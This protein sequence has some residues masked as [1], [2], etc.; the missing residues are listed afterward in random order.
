MALQRVQKNIPSQLDDKQLDNVIMER[1]WILLVLI[2]SM[3]PLML[4]A[5]ADASNLKT[6]MNQVSAA[7]LRRT[8]SGIV[9][10]TRWPSAQTVPTL[11]VFS[12][13]HFAAV[14]TDTRNE[15][16]IPLFNTILIEDVDDFSSSHCDAVYFGRESI[17]E[18]VGISSLDPAHPLLTISEQNPECVDGSAFCLIFADKKVSFSVN[19]DSLF[20]TGVKV[21]PEVLMLGRPRNAKHG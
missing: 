8:V 20:R 18:Q 5:R 1:R 7:D 13:A 15:Q 16:D 12:S 6:E 11:C 9:S 2:F 10:Y 21:S 14:L 4:L 17:Q 19:L 3:L